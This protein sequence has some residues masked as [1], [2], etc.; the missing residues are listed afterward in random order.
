MANVMRW[1]SGAMKPSRF[2]SG[3]GYEIEI[4]D[5]LFFEDGIAK[6]ACVM[7][8]KAALAQ[9][10]RVSFKKLREKFS[11]KFIGVA[12]ESSPSHEEK[13][14]LVAVA[15]VFEFDCFSATFVCRDHIRPENFWYSGG[16]RLENQNV[17]LAND[18][19]TAIGRCVERTKEAERVLVDIFCKRN[20]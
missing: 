6:P 3:L 2:A 10:I 8:E 9:D 1:R 18:D 12:M 17:T 14:I 13:Q 15:G 16:V 20:K 11:A 7:R 19:A 4:G 5:M